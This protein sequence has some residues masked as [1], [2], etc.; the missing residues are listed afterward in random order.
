MAEAA[1]TGPMTEGKPL[2]WRRAAV[3][4][5]ETLTY[6]PSR[7]ARGTHPASASPAQDRSKTSQ[8]ALPGTRSQACHTVPWGTAALETQAGDAGE[9]KRPLG[10]AL[11]ERKPVA[12]A[13]TGGKR[14][15]IR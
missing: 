3:F 9:E 2:F 14:K 13:P 15:L 4:W 12:P 7:S 8:H 5:N 10:I 1:T 6:A 11:T